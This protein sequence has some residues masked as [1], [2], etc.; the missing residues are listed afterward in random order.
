MKKRRLVIT[1]ALGLSL[2]LA[3]LWILGSLSSSAVAAPSVGHVEAPK[4]PAAE[5]H[6]CPA[7]PPTCDYSSVQTAVDAANSGD[8]IKVASGI[9]TGVSARESVTQ[10]VYISK[11]VTVQGGY[12]TSNWTISRPQANPTTLDAQEQG[13]VLYIIGNIS[14]TVEGLRITGGYVKASGGGIYNKGADLALVNTIITN[15]IS[16]GTNWP[17][18]L[19]G[20]VSVWGG[21][22]T[23]NGGQVISNSATYKGGGVSVWGGSVTLN[24]G[25]IINNIAN[26]PTYWDGGGGVWV[27]GSATLIGGQI[28][29]NSAIHGGGLYVYLS[30]VTLR[31]VQIIDNS[32]ASSGGGVFIWPGSVVTLN[33]GGISNNSARSCGGVAGGGTFTLTNSVVSDN[34]AEGS[35]SG[36]CIS[37][38][39]SR[40]LHTTIARNLGGDGIGVH[41]AGSA[42]VAMTN[43]IVATHTVGIIVTAGSTAALESTLW[44]GNATKWDG[45]GTIDHSNDHTGDPAFVA[46]DAGDYHISSSSAAVDAGVDAGV[47]DDMDGHTRPFDGD[48]DGAD[49][50]D[51]GADEYVRWHIYLPLVLRKNY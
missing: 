22:V 15:N 47:T 43:T 19:G 33:G 40:L 37:G 2:A 11:T 46:P 21:S 14:P 48:D 20:G 31:E 30:N 24:G 42:T 41:V 27:L 4:A 45:A 12:T 5:L 10:V 39:S 26:G 7:G 35:G 49:E 51:I 28:I 50:F 38:D 36:L 23:L 9:Y 3:L 1:L 8:L 34:R 6:V 44:H 29:S 32:A 25:Q 17:D 18:G 16:S 13:R